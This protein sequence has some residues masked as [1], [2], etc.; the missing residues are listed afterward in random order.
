[1][2]PHLAARSGELDDLGDLAPQKC[3]EWNAP[4]RTY[5]SNAPVECFRTSEHILENSMTLEALHR[6]ARI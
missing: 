5:H 4:T 1:M 6:N 2:F 3:I